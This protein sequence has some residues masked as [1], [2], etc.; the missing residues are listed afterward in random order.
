MRKT[1]FSM[2]KASGKSLDL[3]LKLYVDHPMSV[4]VVFKGW[5]EP[6][7]CEPITKVF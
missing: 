5:N 4:N 2:Y 3:L 6:I 7:N 1:L